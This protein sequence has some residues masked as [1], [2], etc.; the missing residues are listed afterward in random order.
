M[1]LVVYTTDDTV[2]EIVPMLRMVHNVQIVISKIRSFSGG[3]KP[4]MSQLLLD[5][6]NDDV[7][8]R[9]KANVTLADHSLR[10]LAELGHPY[11]KKYPADSGPHPD[12]DVHE[13]SGELVSSTVVEVSS[14]GGNQAV[15][16]VNSSAHYEYVRYGTRTMRPRDP[17]G[18]ALADA[19][20][21]IKARFAEGV[22]GAAIEYFES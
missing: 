11:S 3:F 1:A 6:M 15:R 9:W 17:G 18:E 5:A 12:Y 2:Y 20:P 22:Q 21:D 7:M 13:Q 10:E 19:M 16:L 8:P 14:V 4:Y